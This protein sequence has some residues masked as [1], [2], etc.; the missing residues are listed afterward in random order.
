MTGNGGPA[1]RL[2]GSICE[3]ETGKRE[4]SRAR[5]CVS[6][7]R[8]LKS[9]DKAPDI[10][11]Q[12][13]TMAILAECPICHSKQ[14]A[15]NKICKCGIDLDKAK[16]GG[17]VRY[18]IVYRLPNGKQRKEY[19]GTKISEA[20]DADGKRRGEKREN[21]LWE[22]RPDSKMTFAELAKWYLN[23]ENVKD[24][25]SY[26]LIELCLG[27]FNAEFGDM[28][29]ADIKL[30]DLENYQVKR[31]KA[32][33][34]P[35]TIDHEIGKPKTMILKAFDN[36]LVGGEVLKAFKRCKKT[37][38][39]GADVRDRILSRLEFDSLITKSPAH[40]KPILIAA[41]YTGMR[42]SEILNLT[43]DRVDMKSRTIR[44]DAE[45]TKDREP[46]TVPICGELSE[47]LKSIPRGLHDPH[48]FLYRGKP[49]T[50]I[51]RALR[52]GCKDAGIKYGRFEAGGFVFHDLRHTFNTNMRKAGVSESVI[53][54]ITGHSTRE[55]FDRYNTIDS[56]DKQSAMGKLEGF[57]EN[58]AQTV[59]QVGVETEKENQANG[60]D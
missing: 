32:G 45:H 28:I 35:A 50:D 23:L 3:P 26:W 9:S 44:L 15:K 52:K 24:L 18:W 11:K 22:I 36:D 58:V 17:R 55:M 34:A 31:K 59:A 5:G 4:F 48:V 7:N 54:A 53:M 49:I 43:W 46:R 39:P 57:L 12:G 33:L 13:E 8:G 21:R 41:F 6:K 20:R 25:A 30:A 60:G 1:I 10:Q 38:K 37:L 51:R 42:K 29:V 40:I 16:N 56:D 14:S 2:P 19:V 47:A 27:K